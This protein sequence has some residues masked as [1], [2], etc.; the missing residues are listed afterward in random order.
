MR[1]KDYLGGKGL[2]RYAK[3]QQWDIIGVLNNDMIG[4]IKG[5]D[6]VIDNRSFRI[7]SRTG[8]TNGK[9]NKNERPGVFY[10]GEVD[11]IS[12]QLAR[13]IHKTVTTYMPEMNPMMVY[14]LDRFWSW[15]TPQAI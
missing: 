14:R 6:G 2:A 5:V 8:T 10:G 1:N 9:L 4:N 15:W 3:D 13:Y 11:G 12:R 7:F